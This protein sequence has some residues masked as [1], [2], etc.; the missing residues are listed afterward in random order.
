M[1]SLLILDGHYSHTRNIDFLSLARQ[2]FVTI[3]SLL[4][5]L[6]VDLNTITAKKQENLYV[7][8]KER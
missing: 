3:I 5:Y 4:N 6:W 1:P 8:T 7:K 2:N